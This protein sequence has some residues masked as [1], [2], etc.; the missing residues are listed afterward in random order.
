L[1]F[2]RSERTSWNR[3]DIDDEH[4]DE[5][6]DDDDGSTTTTTRRPSLQVNINNKNIFVE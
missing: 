1:C 6:L 3:E 4:V 5:I 2:I